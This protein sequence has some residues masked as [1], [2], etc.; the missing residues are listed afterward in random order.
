MHPKISLFPNNEFYHK[1][2]MDGPNVKGEK[3]E[4]R[5]LTGDIFG[6]YS[7]INVSNGNEEQDERYS[8][9]NK[10]EA[11]VVAE[12]VFNLHKGT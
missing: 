9:R 2:I 4:K 3:Y 8:T 10:P 5:F 6:P 7:F 1:K 11:F 12:I